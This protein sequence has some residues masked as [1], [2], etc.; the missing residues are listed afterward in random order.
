MQL[1]ELTSLAI[2]LGLGLLVGLER[3]RAE[4]G[5]A[6]IRTFALIT[7]LG[8]LT[9]ILATQFGGWIIAAALVAVAAMLVLGNV[10]R[11]KAG[12]ADAGITTAA[13]ALVMFGVGAAVVA[14]YA[15]AAV[16]VSGTVALLLHWKRPLH[17][18]V[19]N[20]GA[21]EFRAIMRLVLIAL[22]ILPLLPNRAYGPYGVLNPFQIW[23][24]VVL[25]VGIS[26][27]AYIVYK[28]LGPRAGTLLGG[29][30]GGLISSTAATVSY[31]R[32]SRTSP[33]SVGAASVMITIASTVVFIRVLFE[34]A[35][36]AP[37]VLPAVAPPLLAMFALLA[38]LS[39]GSYFAAR[40][41]LR[42]PAP[43]RPPSDLRIAIVFGTL[44]AVV[45]I[46]IAFAR[47][48]L[49]SRGLYTVAALSGLT[50]MDAITLSTA[51][52]VEARQLEV[53]AGWRLILTGA[54]ANLA[55]KGAAVAVL[56]NRRLF[57]RI[58]LL[59]GL[60]IAGGAAILRFWPGP[61]SP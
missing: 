4:N 46:A 35:V 14:G 56:G 11:L 20:L 16:A 48:H 29:A 37:T 50:D 58:A 59:F 32:R 1:S 30:L 39:A 8:A 27:A 10:L 49:G 26:L 43:A 55:F 5:V 19:R 38:A 61:S 22:V 13:A 51:K 57:A 42:E 47:E 60:A 44:F 18:L 40:E 7:L 41:E 23:L 28:L 9:A 15:A 17:G 6:G 31:S 53:E 34:V 21:D 24:L 2:A 3:E 52:L 36:V 45:L 33:D 54:L 25:I 12:R